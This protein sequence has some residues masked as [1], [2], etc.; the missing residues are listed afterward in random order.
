[1]KKTIEELAKEAKEAQRLYDTA[2]HEAKNSSGNKRIIATSDAKGFKWD[3]D[4]PRA[5]VIKHTKATLDNALAT[6]KSDPLTQIQLV[7]AIM[8]SLKKAADDS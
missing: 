7:M 6:L 3:C 8:E 4:A 1:M 5:L 2:L